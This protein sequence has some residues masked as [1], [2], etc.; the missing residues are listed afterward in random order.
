MK[1]KKNIRLVWLAIVFGGVLLITA[2]A[3][4]RNFEIARNLDIFNTLFRELVVNYVDE[5]NPSEV[6]QKGIDEMLKSLDPYTTFIPESD[7]EDVRFMTT[8]QYGG[9]GALLHQRD[10]YSYISEPHKGFPAQK[11]GLLAGDR[12]LEINGQPAG[13]LR[14]DEVRL[15]LQGQPGT[16][17][18]LLIEREGVEEP[19]LKSMEREVVT[20]DNV[21][22]YGMLDEQTAYINLSQFTRHAGREVRNAF[23]ALREEHDVQHLVLDLRGNGGGLLH[24]AVNVANLF[25]EKNEVIVRTKGR[26]SDRNTTHRTLNDPLD[27]DIPLVVLVDRASASASEIVAGAI[28]DLD[29]GVVLGRRTFGKGL[30][31]NVLP[32]SYNAQLKVTVAKYYIPSGRCI[33]AIDYAQRHE[34]GSVKAIPDAHKTAFRTRNGRVVYDGGGVEPDLPVELPLAGHITQ[35]LYRQ[36]MIFD[37]ATYFFRKHEQIPP[38]GQFQITDEIYADFEAFL[39]QREFAYTTESERLLERVRQVTKDELYFESIAD[40]YLAL[41]SGLLSHKDQDLQVFRQEI[42]PLLRAE[43][44]SRYH[45]QRGRVEA[46]LA[47]DPEILAALSLFA[48][49]ERY[50]ALLQAP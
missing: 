42:E 31:Q 12:I 25:I 10:G 14:E 40:E 47:G 15:L 22:Y 9:I 13:S 19:L 38:A 1:K 34:D 33:Q 43:I 7:I 18:N 29:R 3:G 45:Y 11:A 17:V 35:A 32:L 4:S 16:S 23:L 37:Y 44:A 2:A 5:V 26:L 30:V 48:Q 41:K 8:G 24:E 50:R 39:Q 6:M 20:I 46:S 21:P 36:F 28:Q 49:P 27:L